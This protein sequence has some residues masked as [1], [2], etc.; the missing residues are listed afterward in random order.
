MFG[1]KSDRRHGRQKASRSSFSSKLSGVSTITSTTTTSNGSNIIANETQARRRARTISAKGSLAN[2]LKTSSLSYTE[3][4]DNPANNTPAEQEHSVDVFQFLDTWESR[5][6]SRAASQHSLV[7]ESS[8]RSSTIPETQPSHFIPYEI[9]P[10][11]SETFAERENP[12]HDDDDGVSE[13]K[14]ELNKDSFL[15][16][17]HSDSGISI[18]RHSVDHSAFVKG[19]DTAISELAEEKSPH[20]GVM[21][22]V[23]I[24]GTVDDSFGGQSSPLSVEDAE[25]FYREASS[26]P[27]AYQY[28]R[29]S[30]LAKSTKRAQ[31]A[32][33][34]SVIHA[35]DTSVGDKKRPGNTTYRRFERLN[36]KV[37]DSLQDELNYLEKLCDTIDIDDQRRTSIGTR[38]CVTCPPPYCHPT[39][40][41]T[42]QQIS[43]HDLLVQTRIKLEEY[44]RALYYYGKVRDSFLTS[45]EQGDRIVIDR[46]PIGRIFSLS[47]VQT[48]CL[49]FAFIFPLLAFTLISSMFGRWSFV[50]SVSALG[51]YGFKIKFSQR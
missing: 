2:K 1:F 22:S 41:N 8:Q 38:P 7:T 40:P 4:A 15:Q 13:M 51:F 5:A 32:G 34:S 50:F 31:E 21:D 39:C 43:R 18:G 24:P 3:A 19:Q 11:Q 42:F 12:A 37:L 20:F 44:N 45:P 47:T 33:V 27:S 16:S 25:S 26:S 29:N 9:P 49:L 48:A 10:E 46:P 6:G 35:G 14:E 30:N 28:L 36:R 17:F 23:R